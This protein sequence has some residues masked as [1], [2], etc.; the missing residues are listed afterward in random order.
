M[1]NDNIWQGQVV[2]LSHRELESCAHTLIYLQLPTL[3]CDFCV[4][5][6]EESLITHSFDSLTTT[7]WISD[8]KKI[9]LQRN[10]SLNITIT[11]PKK[12]GQWEDGTVIQ[13]MDLRA[14]ILND[15]SCFKWRVS[16]EILANE[17]I[18]PSQWERHLT[19]KLLNSVNND[20][21]QRRKG[22]LARK[23][24]LKWHCFKN[25]TYS[26]FVSLL[27]HLYFRALLSHIR[28]NRMKWGLSYIE[29]WSLAI[30]YCSSYIE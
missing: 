16:L 18:K 26:I 6:E 1:S 17:S 23:N 30:S 8:L 7:T 24:R 5:T 10:L 2:V 13:N 14:T 27:F 20:V 28:L 4:P 22:S 19:S 29:A 12:G 3:S 21:L 15:K 11:M 9:I 25:I